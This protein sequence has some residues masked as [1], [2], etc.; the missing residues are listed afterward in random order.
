MDHV[1]AEVLRQWQ[2]PQQLL[3]C[4]CCGDGNDGGDVTARRRRRVAVVDVLIRFRLCVAV[5]IIIFNVT[6][7]STD[8]IALIVGVVALLSLGCCRCA[9]VAVSSLDAASVVAAVA[10]AVGG[11]NVAVAF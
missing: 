3:W 9:V 4:C 2:Q 1:A 7:A 11:H 5:A 10:I 8:V 6:I